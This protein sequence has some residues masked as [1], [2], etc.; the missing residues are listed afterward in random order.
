MEMILTVKKIEKQ[1]NLEVMHLSEKK[2]NVKKF[3]F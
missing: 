1:S 3:R 2:V